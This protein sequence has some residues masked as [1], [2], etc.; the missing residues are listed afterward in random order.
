MES[1]N[2]DKKSPPPEL[3][4]DVRREEMDLIFQQCRADDWGSVLHAVT[5][6]PLVGLGQMV[7]DNHI[8]TTIIHQAITSKGDTNL[9]ARV[10]LKILEGT[11]AAAAIR[12]GY[13]SLPLHVIAQRN[14]KMKAET[15]EQLITALVHANVEAL[16]TEGGTGKRTPLHIIFTGKSTR[17]DGSTM[18]AAGA[19]A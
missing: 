17:I 12:N 10:I 8:S 11:P 6:N 16:A 3:P 15:K 13:G 5:E 19:G 18:K 2:N 1:G 14:T 7:M 9:R 4:A